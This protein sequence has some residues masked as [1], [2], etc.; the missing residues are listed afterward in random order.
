MPVALPRLSKSTT[1]T[2]MAGKRRSVDSHQVMGGIAIIGVL[3][4][5]IGLAMQRID[6]AV[7]AGVFAFLAIGMVGARGNGDS[8]NGDSGAYGG[9][10][11]GCGGGDGGGGD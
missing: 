2:F 6:V 8:G 4:V 10:G 9:D 3:A 7:M 5:M 1:R 11:S